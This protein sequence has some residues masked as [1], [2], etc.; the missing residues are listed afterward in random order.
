MLAVFGACSM[1]PLLIRL[2]SSNGLVCESTPVVFSNEPEE[3]KLLS[4]AE[5]LPW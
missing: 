1:D 3:G 5:E 4:E 2:E